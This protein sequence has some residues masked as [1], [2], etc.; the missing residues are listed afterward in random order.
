L[1]SQENFE[2]FSSMSNSEEE[3]YLLPFETERVHV[4][5]YTE[6]VS[7]DLGEISLW[8]AIILLVVSI[9]QLLIEIKKA[10]ERKMENNK[11]ENNI[12]KKIRNTIYH[13]K[14]K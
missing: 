5:S 14:K 8:V 13:I 1:I 10:K 3:S 4:L 2:N 11:M 7:K 9:I 12:I 6:V